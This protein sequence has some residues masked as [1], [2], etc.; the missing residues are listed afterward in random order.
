[1]SFTVPTS[2]T[3]PDFAGLEPIEVPQS[4]PV[5]S[6]AVLIQGLGCGVYTSGPKTGYLDTIQ[7]GVGTMLTVGISYNTYTNTSSSPNPNQKIAVAIGTPWI[8]FGTST[9]AVTEANVGDIVYWKTPQIVTPDSAAGTRSIAGVCTGIGGQAGDTHVGQCKVEMRLSASAALQLI[10]ALTGLSF[11]LTP[12]Q[13]GTGLATIP[14]HGLMI[15]EATSNVASLGTTLGGIPIAQGASADPVLTTQMGQVHNV[16]GVV[17][18]AVSDLSS[19]TVASNDGLT[20][21]AGDR[22]LLVSQ[23][24]K[25]QN[26]IYVVGSVTT[27][28]APLTRPTDFATG[29]VLPGGVEFSVNAGT[30]FANSQWKIT[31]AGAITVGTTNFDAFPKSVTQSLALVAGTTTITNVPILS[32]TKSHILVT[33]KVANTSALTTGGYATNGA[34]TPGII[35]TATVDVF[36]TIA[37]GTIN[38]ADIS[39]LE[40]TIMNW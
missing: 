12:A 21:V 34:A 2:S 10:S 33:R 9:D 3:M 8:P 23:A 14:A 13:G 32:A 26:G 38:V 7:D 36:A 17:T 29:A 25:S 1:M 40:I 28:A 22:V 6:D 11:P 30:L 19:F 35:G 37:A 18:A 24:T 4:F 20:Y 5:A 39:T 31:T 27:G 15:G 16:R